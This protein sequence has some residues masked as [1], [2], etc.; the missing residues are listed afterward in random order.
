MPA[1]RVSVLATR[2]EKATTMDDAKTQIDS[3]PLDDPEL[4]QQLDPDFYHEALLHIARLAAERLLQERGTSADIERRSKIPL[5]T[6]R[7]LDAITAKSIA[8]KESL[9]HGQWLPWLKENEGMLGFVERRANRTLK[10]DMN[11][12]SA[13]EVSRA[14]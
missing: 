9:E 5:G 1:C 12:S 8:I 14:K 6:S 2:P 7:P 10:S 4:P 13:L 3:T 11:S